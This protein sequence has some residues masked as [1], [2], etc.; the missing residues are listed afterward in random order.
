ME[1]D[2]EVN[3]ALE[4]DGWTVI[5]VWGSEITHDVET[6]AD[7][8]EIV[9]QEKRAERGKKRGSLKVVDVVAAIVVRDGAVLATQRGYGDWEGW[10]EFPGGKIEPGETPQAALVREIHEELNAEIA[11][12]DC[13]CTAE[14]DYPEFHLSMRCYLCELVD[15]EFQLLEHHAARWLTA[16]SIGEVRWLPAD[17]QV[18]D[19]IKRE[20][21]SRGT[22]AFQTF[23]DFT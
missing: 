4:A 8:I 18:V 13:L 10:W 12:G 3:A 21:G 20:L 22:Q 11:V 2:R 5:R 19:A 17:E 14:Y 1:R 6:V 9:Y 23:K 15:P 16:D 7:R